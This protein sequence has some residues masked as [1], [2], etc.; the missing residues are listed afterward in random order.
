MWL[1]GCAKNAQ[2]PTMERTWPQSHLDYLIELESYSMVFRTRAQDTEIIQFKPMEY[3]PTNAQRLFEEI[4]AALPDTDRATCAAATMVFAYF[5]SRDSLMVIHHSEP[6]GSTLSF[7]RDAQ[8][9]ECFEFSGRYAPADLELV[10]EAGPQPNAMGGVPDDATF[11]LLQTIQPS[12]ARYPV[13][14]LITPQNREQS[15]FLT[16]KQAM[17]YLYQNGVFGT[18]DTSS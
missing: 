6:G 15:D 16:Q 1:V 12:A 7:C 3:S 4:G 8:R 18:F 11:D 10:F 9:A 2:Y 5:F 13:D 14:E 17:D